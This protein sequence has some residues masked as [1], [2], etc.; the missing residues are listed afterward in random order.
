VS[1]SQLKPF[2]PLLGETY[3][4]FFP[5]HGIDIYCEHTSHHPPIANFLLLNPNY[6]YSGRYEFVAKLSNNTLFIRQEGPNCVEFKDGSKVIFHLP[7]IKVNGMLLG[8]RTCYYNGVAKFED[9]KNK[10]KAIVKMGCG[11]EKKSGFFGGTKKRHDQFEGKIYYYDPSATK[12]E[13]KNQQDE[14]KEDLKYADLDKEITPISG[15]F[16]ENL[17]FGD[18]EFW[19]IDKVKPAA[20]KPTENPLPSDVRFRED[21]V[22]LKYG[23]MKHAEDWKLRLEEQQRWD[24]KLRLKEK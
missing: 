18:T 17:K 15:S 9:P 11:T 13:S 2:N 10:V 24:R 6:K 1:A 4:G 14:D 19:H 16:L 21:L 7:G 20:Y 22:W 8:D 12:V 23:N 3:Q 5:G